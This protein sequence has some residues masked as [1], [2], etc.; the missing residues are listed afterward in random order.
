MN[1]YPLATAWLIVGVVVTGGGIQPRQIASERRLNSA[2]GAPIL[3]RYESIR[4]AQDW[5]NPYLT[6]CPQGVL[7]DVRS[8]KRVNDTVSPETLREM[9]LDLPVKAWPY[10]RI[11]ALQNCSL[12]SPGDTEDRN[13]RMLEVEDVLKTLGLAIDHWPR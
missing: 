2:I 4:D 10:G 11:V 6:V 9:L 5:L 3:N 7:L 8:V 13:K 1:V 12:G